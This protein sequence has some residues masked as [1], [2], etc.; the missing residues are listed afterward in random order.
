MNRPHG[1]HENPG[2]AFVARRRPISE[3]VESGTGEKHV[4]LATLSAVPLDHHDLSQ[5]LV[6]L[7]ST[8]ATELH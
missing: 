1:S 2:A 3:G 5:W 4:A 7:M 6:R 8:G